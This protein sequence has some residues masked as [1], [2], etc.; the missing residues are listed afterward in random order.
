MNEEGGNVRADFRSVNK[1]KEE[2]S[3]A[4]GSITANAE[5]PIFADSN[6]LSPLLQTEENEGG[7]LRIELRRT[8]NTRIAPYTEL[9]PNYI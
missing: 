9:L 8:F 7:Q 1:R 4:Q 2:A 5:K 6:V 3:N